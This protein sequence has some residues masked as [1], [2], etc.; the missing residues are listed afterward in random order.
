V[1]VCTVPGC[2]GKAASRGLCDRHY[3][4]ARRH[5]G[6]YA[7]AKR[8]PPQKA[9]S[10]ADQPQNSDGNHDGYDERFCGLFLDELELRGSPRYPQGPWFTA[11]YRAD[12]EYRRLGARLKPIAQIPESTGVHESLW[13]HD[14]ESDL[15]TVNAACT[16]WLARH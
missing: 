6:F 13:M 12:D 2:T 14:H 5:G 10:A 3:R 16:R 1:P 7:P 11:L 9:P 15:K 8:G 4:V